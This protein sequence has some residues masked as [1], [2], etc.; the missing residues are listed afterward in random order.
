MSDSEDLMR[1]IVKDLTIQELTEK[2]SNQVLYKV[3][4]DEDSMAKALEHIEQAL[5][6]AY[7]KGWKDALD[8]VVDKLG[9]DSF[10]DKRKEN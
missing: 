7:E 4:T 2:L 10:L 6:Q 8:K 5:S 1:V 3:P 9:E